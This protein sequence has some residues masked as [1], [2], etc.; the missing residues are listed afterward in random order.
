MPQDRGGL[1]ILGETEDIIAQLIA[2]QLISITKKVEKLITMK[3]ETIEMVDELLD[4]LIFVSY[5]N[6]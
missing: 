2:T 5:K 6:T 4:I 3:Q 1:I